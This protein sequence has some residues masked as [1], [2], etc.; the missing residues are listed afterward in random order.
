MKNEETEF[1]WIIP[2]LSK[3]EREKMNSLTLEDC[4]KGLSEA[5][6]IWDFN[7]KEDGKK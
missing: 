2:N 1:E 7:K 4:I 3:E 6:K 5:D